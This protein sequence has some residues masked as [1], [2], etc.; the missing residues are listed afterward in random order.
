MLGN[1]LRA[2]LSR[3]NQYFQDEIE[4]DEAF[5]SMEIEE[6]DLD[7]HGRHK[8]NW[9]QRNRAAAHARLHDFYFAEEPLFGPKHFN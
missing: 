6:K 1:F 8:R 9:I 2:H 7:E 4:E 3:M 5:L